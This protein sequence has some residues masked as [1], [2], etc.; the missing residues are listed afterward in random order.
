L[1]SGG[2]ANL[3][4]NKQDWSEDMVR[5]REAGTVMLGDSGGFQIAKGLWEGEW[6]DPTSPEVV[7]KMAELRAKVLNM[8]R[9]SSQMALPSTTRMAT[10][11]MSRLIMLKTIR[12]C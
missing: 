12:T 11:S 6:R 10:K 9:I 1:Y 2:H 7:A 4:L 8:Y 3:D 5:S